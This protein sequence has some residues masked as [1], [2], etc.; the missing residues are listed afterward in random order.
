MAPKDAQCSHEISEA[1]TT[2]CRA[3]L[4][5]ETLGDH[6]LSSQSGEPVYAC[7]PGSVP[8][9]QKL[10]RAAGRR[11][12]GGL[13]AFPFLRALQGTDLGDGRGWNSQQPAEAVPSWAHMSTLYFFQA[14]PEISTL[15][16]YTT[17]VP[18]LV[19]LGIT[20]IKDLVDDV[21][22]I[23]R[24]TFCSLQCVST[25]CSEMIKIT[26]LLLSSKGSS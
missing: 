19:V 11:V 26:F 6:W 1:A 21:V 15:A 17:L 3:G 18:L 16:W 4:C 13:D 10:E 24:A 20:A 23:A 7:S 8:G 2:Y 9:G 5:P 25:F 14:I 12:A 22:R